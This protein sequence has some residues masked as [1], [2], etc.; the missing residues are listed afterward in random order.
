MI[1]H[2]DKILNHGE[3]ALFSNENLLVVA[4]GNGEWAKVSYYF[5]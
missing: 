5:I 2:P 4:D 1:P 3:D